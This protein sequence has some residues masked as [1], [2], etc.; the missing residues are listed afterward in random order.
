M[1]LLALSGSPSNPSI[2]EQ[3][4]RCACSM[5][6]RH[7]VDFVSVRDVEAP[8]YSAEEEDG[9]GILELDHRVGVFRRDV[10]L[11]DRIAVGGWQTFDV[12]RLLDGHRHPVKRPARAILGERRIRRP[13]AL[14]GLCRMT[15]L[16]RVD[17]R[18]E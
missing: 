3:L 11:E 6:T 9:P 18:L 1:T 7:E 17:L 12:V 14:A 15:P 5:V 2:N 8:F 16:P 4:L 10:V 13:S